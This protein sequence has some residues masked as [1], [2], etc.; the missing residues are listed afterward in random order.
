MVNGKFKQ[1]PSKKKWFIVIGLVVLLS[2]FGGGVYA[3][4]DYQ[5]KVQEEEER[6][7]VKVAK[8]AIMALYL[9]EQKKALANDINTGKIE[10]AREK[11]H[12]VVSEQNKVLL[13]KELSDVESLLTARE[14]VE[15][16][17]IDG[18][19]TDNVEE[20][21]INSL[22]EFITEIDVVNNG[23]LSTL[24]NELNEIK[25]QY[26]YLIAVKKNVNALFSDATFEMIND[27]TTREQYE[28]AK[29]S[30]DGVLNKKHKTELNSLLK[31]VEISL[32][33]K[34]EAEKKRIAAEKK[35]KEEL[36]KIKKQEAEEKAE[37]ERLAVEQKEK[38]ISKT[39]TANSS[40]GMVNKKKVEV[41]A[42]A[43]KK[44]Q[45]SSPSKPT[46]IQGVLIASKKYP[47]PTNYAPGE[48]SKARSAFNQMAA[49]AKKEGFNLTA[50]STY[51]S[52]V[53]QKGLFDRYANQHGVDEANRFS[54]RAGQSEHQTGLAFDVGEVGKEHDWARQAFGETNAG[55]WIAKNA[56]HFGFIVRYPR[57]KENVTGYI[58][59]P[60]H[61]RYLQTD[62]ATKVY[63]SGLTLEEYLG[64]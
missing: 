4:V 31:S 15:S 3:Y 26:E 33:L 41:K 5:N 60:W 18:V 23:F 42:T 24:N 49:A 36:E 37:K 16:L 25:S 17:F 40:S 9:D 55:K 32:T 56:H 61:L 64:I 14:K 43:D 54:A 62:I 52:Y 30:I 29:D 35:E 8:Q 48:S 63:N 51:R 28:K 7:A 13:S 10:A 58:Y 11:I 2:G 44:Q 39:K 50:F 6:L 20:A 59:E 19:L 34:E 22:E 12:A 27:E 57:G 47:L 21:Q 46:Y 38:D 1:P 53:Y 45:T